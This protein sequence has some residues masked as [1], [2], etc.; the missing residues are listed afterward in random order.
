[1]CVLVVCRMSWM[2][3]LLN[4]G[5]FEG[6]GRKLISICDQ[7]LLSRK[8]KTWL[9][10]SFSVEEFLYQKCC[11][12][13][14]LFECIS[15]WQKVLLMMTCITFDVFN[16]SSIQS[17]QLDYRMKE[18][19][20]WK[21]WSP[22]DILF[23]NNLLPSLEE[24]HFFSECSL[25]FSHSLRALSFFLH[26]FP[27]PLFQGVNL[28]RKTWIKCHLVIESCKE[29]NDGT[30]WKIERYSI[31][32]WCSKQMGWR[33]R[34]ERERERVWKRRK[35]NLADKTCPWLFPLCE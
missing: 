32:N 19:N 26:L 29:K 1:M 31:Q 8:E 6:K 2:M 5:V 35:V 24:W 9:K 27:S 15:H 22:F 10:T 11:W 12:L 21:W 25:P 14:S 13:F 3:M 16:D 28:D 4:V 20:G 17:L 23:S 7:E 33:S 18:V 30:W 34:R